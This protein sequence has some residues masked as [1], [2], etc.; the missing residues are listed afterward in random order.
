[1]TSVEV[2]IGYCMLGYLVGLPAAGII[3]LFLGSRRKPELYNNQPY[4]SI[5][6]HVIFSAFLF[7]FLFSG[8]GYV[9]I[10]VGL[11]YLIKFI[12]FAETQ[13]EVLALKN[14]KNQFDMN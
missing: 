7:A 13:E 10:G 5:F 14:T 12:V 11:C 4:M 1:M 3:F 8:D 6:L 9:A 2:M